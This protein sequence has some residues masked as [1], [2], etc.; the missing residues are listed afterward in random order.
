VTY[1]TENPS[2]Q[3]ECYIRKILILTTGGLVFVAE[4]TE[5]LV[6][7]FVAPD[8][9]LCAGPVRVLGARGGRAVDLS[10]LPDDIMYRE[11]TT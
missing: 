5:G 7:E 11:F 10:P 6:F 9:G 3:G 4:S 2:F 1:Y 8:N